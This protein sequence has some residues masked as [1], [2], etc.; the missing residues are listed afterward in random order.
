M[1]YKPTALCKRDDTYGVVC[2]KCGKCGRRFS[3]YGVDDTKVIDKLVSTRGNLLQV[4]VWRLIQLRY[5]KVVNQ[6][7]SIDEVLKQ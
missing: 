6:L 3:A 2:V 5:R 4:I 7:V 1:A